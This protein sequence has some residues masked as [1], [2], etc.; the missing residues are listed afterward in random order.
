[1]KVLTAL[2]DNEIKGAKPRISSNGNPLK[3]E[4]VDSTRERGV[5]R[6]VVRI[7]VVGSRE[8]A[9]KYKIGSKRVYIQLGRYP[10]MS[11]VDARDA[12]KPL[13]KMLKEG[14]NPKDELKRLSQEKALLEHNESMQ[15][16]IKQLFVAYTDNMKSRGKRTYATVLKDLEKETYPIIP[17]ETKA[18]EVTRQQIIIVL[19]KLISRGAPVQSNRVRSYLMTAFNYGLKHDND[20]KFIDKELSFG[21]INNPVI[22]I[23]KQDDVEKVGERYLLWPEVK[24]VLSE[25]HKTPRVGLTSSLLMKLCIYTGGQRPY[26]I[27]AS[28]WKDVDW[29]ERILVIPGG[30][31]KNHKVHLVPLSISAIDVLTEL[32]KMSKGSPFIFPQNVNINKHYLT[33][34]FSTAVN[35]FLDATPDFKPFDP[36][37]I[38]RTAKTLMGGLGVSKENRDILQNHSKVDVSSK[39]YDRYDYLKEKRHAIDVWE[40]KLVKLM[41]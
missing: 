12:I 37:D 3:Y 9:Y 21:I 2:T 15:G 25:F 4:L 38:R 30:I 13:I 31:S 35:R 7:T 14:L 19:S 24:T 41:A 29:N 33:S 36:R 1:M 39:H 22:G 26:E 17:P 11:L 8:F 6:L 16:S 40:K 34:S 10:S 20:P 5:G 18:K 28:L 23:P 27:S 32:K